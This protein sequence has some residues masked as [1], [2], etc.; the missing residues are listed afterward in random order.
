MAVLTVN[1]VNRTG[2]NVT[3]LLAAVAAGGDSFPNTGVEF[4]LFKNTNA[5]T[6]II[7]MDIQATVD[8]QAVTDRTYTIA[9]TTGEVLLGP[10]PTSTYN[11]G[12]NRVNFT[13]S[14]DADLK[15]AVFALATN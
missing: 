4:V 1:Q 5:A 3:S 9:A 12:N 14:A 7:T 8:G 11:D 15:V 10:F 2:A 13:Y 6:R